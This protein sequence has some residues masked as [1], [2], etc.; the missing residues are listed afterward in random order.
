MQD[1]LFK[2]AALSTLKCMLHVSLKRYTAIC[3]CDHK[4]TLKEVC[5]VRT[6]FRE[7]Y[8]H[9]IILAATRQNPSSGFPSKRDSQQSLA[10]I[11]YN[12]ICCKLTCSYDTFRKTANNEGADQTERMLRLV[13]TSVVRKPPKTGFL[14]SRPISWPS[15]A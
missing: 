9:F 6:L 10:R 13:C 12:F 2:V 8:M 7:L 11:Y 15:R 14:A 3:S 5:T 4:L 1:P